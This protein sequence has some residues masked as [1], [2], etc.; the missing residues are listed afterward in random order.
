MSADEV[1]DTS[2]ATERRLQD[3]GLGMSAAHLV[4]VRAVALHAEREVSVARDLTDEDRGLVALGEWLV[5]RGYRFVTPTPATHHRVNARAANAEAH[6]VEDVLGWSR[7]FRAGALPELER[8]LAAGGV[9][10]RDGEACRS[11]VRFSTLSG[12][13]DEP[14]EPTALFMHSAFPTREASSVFFG[15]DTYRFV[16]ALRRHVRPARRLVDVGCGSGA[17]GIAMLD[18]AAH[19][20]LAD[21]NPD[22]LRVA[23]IN[24]AI[25][26][27]ALDAVSL[28][29][30][31]VLARLDAEPI[32]AVI[33]NPPYL[34][35][36]ERRT[37]RDGGGELGTALALR[38]VDE[39][40]DRLAPGGQLVLYTGSP[41]VGGVHPLHEAV[42][43]ALARRPCRARWEE[44]DPDVFGEELDPQPTPSAYDRVDRIAVITL[45]VD[46]D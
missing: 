17:G 23:R 4:G 11:A 28:I 31:D 9:L 37:Y 22:A 44:V 7:P 26:G 21:I 2:S 27:A 20:V 42:R 38:I 35:D 1:T 25:N 41:V 6:S 10:R 30:S 32:D 34:A 16:A 45:V 40:L 14:E 36:R 39:A 15:P 18:R 24:R 46:V 3:A 12:P 19:V 33:A 43:P 8:L 29:E 5:A 13:R